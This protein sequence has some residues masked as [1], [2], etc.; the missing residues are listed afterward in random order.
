MKTGARRRAR[1]GQAFSP[2][3]EDGGE[4]APEFPDTL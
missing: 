1:C 4:R 3:V 2:R